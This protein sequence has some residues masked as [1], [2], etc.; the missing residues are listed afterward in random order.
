MIMTVHW[1]NPSIPEDVAMAESRIGAETVAAE[2]VLHDLGAISMMSSDSMGMGR[3]GE[4]ILRTWQL[5]DKMKAQRGPKRSMITHE[6]LR[7]VKAK[8][9]INPAIATQIGAHV[10]SFEPGKPPTSSSGG[11][12]FSA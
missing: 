9:T 10:G 4:T 3:V 6:C 5:A 7:S 2:D 8:S 11:P 12:S 1:L